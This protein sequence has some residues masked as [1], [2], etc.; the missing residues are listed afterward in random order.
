MILAPKI[1]KIP[2]LY[3]IFARRMPEYYEK[4]PEKYFFPNFSRGGARTPL[5][6]VSYAYAFPRC[7]RTSASDFGVRS[8][9]RSH[10]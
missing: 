6:P 10:L 5:L 1:N 8:H 9:P 4:L 7:G 3:T 2:E